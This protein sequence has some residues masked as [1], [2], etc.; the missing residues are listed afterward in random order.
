M[1]RIFAWNQ[2]TSHQSPTLEWLLI[3]PNIKC[4]INL[5]HSFPNF[6][7]EAIE[8]WELKGNFIPHFTVH[9]IMF[10][11][12]LLSLG[13]MDASP[14]SKVHGANMGP[15]WVLSAPYGPHVGPMN[16]AIRDMMTRTSNHQVA[17]RLTVRSREASKQAWVLKETRRFEICLSYKSLSNNSNDVYPFRIIINLISKTRVTLR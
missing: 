12:M 17:I 4:G 14:D 9:V 13:Y 1:N 8:S 5:T 3:T 2:W 7:G 11:C 15:T 10:P 6:N 16:L